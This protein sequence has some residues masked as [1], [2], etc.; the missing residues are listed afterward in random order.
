MI[1]DKSLLKKYLVFL[2]RKCQS[3]RT[4]NLWRQSCP[5]PL[6][7][8]RSRRSPGRKTLS[9]YFLTE[10]AAFFILIALVKNVTVHLRHSQY[11]RMH[12]PRT[13]Y[14]HESHLRCSPL[15]CSS[16]LLIKWRSLRSFLSSDSHASMKSEL[17]K[18]RV[19]CKIKIEPDIDS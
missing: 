5:E 18:L 9:A 13:F 10:Q 3:C 12:A 2:P 7:A 16:F 4:V 14:C 15:L 17:G 11:N 6:T 8:E 19:N 1:P